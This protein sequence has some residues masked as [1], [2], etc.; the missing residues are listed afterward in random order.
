MMEYRWCGFAFS[1][2]QFFCSCGKC[3]SQSE[4]GIIFNKEPM[5]HLSYDVSGGLQIECHYFA[6][7]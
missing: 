5:Q 2:L 1:N 4:D 7:L 6:L 3:V